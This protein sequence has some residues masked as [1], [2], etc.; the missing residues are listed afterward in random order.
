[1]SFDI[2]IGTCISVS[3]STVELH[4]DNSVVRKFFP[5]SA[6]QREGISILRVPPAVCS[7]TRKP[8]V[9]EE[10]FL[11]AGALERNQKG[12]LDVGGSGVFKPVDLSRIAKGMTPSLAAPVTT[13]TRW[14]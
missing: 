12:S 3:E 2:G 11:D 8:Q 1:M 10:V 5:E 14:R 6:W 9:G 4:V 7:T 13:K